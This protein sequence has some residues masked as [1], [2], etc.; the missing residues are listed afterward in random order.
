MTAPVDGAGRRR[1]KPWKKHLLIFLATVAVTLAGGTTLLIRYAPPLVLNSAHKAIS[2]GLGNGAN[3]PDNTLYTVPYLASPETAHGNN[4]LLG[5]NQDG[6]YTVGWLDLSKGPELLTIPEM[7]S[8]YHNVEIV[9]PATGV[10][11]ANLKAPGTT[12]IAAAGHVT[13]APHGMSVLDAPGKQVLVIGRTLVE[14]SADLPA[15]LA[16]AQQI[17]VTPYA[18]Q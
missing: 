10:V 7:G 2:A 13:A 3:T 18:G 5:G 17:R 4:W 12:F 11:I 1:M 14:N 16:L 8:R 15:A 9:A 6:L